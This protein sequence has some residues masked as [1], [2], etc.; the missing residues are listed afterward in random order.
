MDLQINVNTIQTTR[1]L[2]SF[3]KKILTQ[4][5]QK[6]KQTFLILNQKLIKYLTNRSQIFKSN[7]KYNLKLSDKKTTLKILTRNGRRTIKKSMSKNSR[8]V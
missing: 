6:N 7:K 8:L 1:N 5:L 3:K 4:H 2:K